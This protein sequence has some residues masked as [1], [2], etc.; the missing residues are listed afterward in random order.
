AV[1]PARAAAPRSPGRR[2]REPQERGP[3][4]RLVPACP[5]RRRIPPG[6]PPAWRRPPPPRRRKGAAAP[7]TRRPPR[8]PRPEPGTTLGGGRRLGGRGGRGGGGRRGGPEPYSRV[9]GEKKMGPR[10]K[11]PP[12]A[13]GN[14]AAG[15]TRDEPTTDGASSFAGTVRAACRK[16]RKRGTSGAA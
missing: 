13:L 4:T 8:R 15:T 3:A 6:R 14:P 2:A 1:P 9:F 12:P 7:P 10:G 5:G 11:P 16:E